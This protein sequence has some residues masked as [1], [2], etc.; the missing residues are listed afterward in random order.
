LLVDDNGTNECV[1]PPDEH[2]VH[3]VEIR[4][5]STV[6]SPVRRLSC[7]SVASSQSPE[8]ATHRRSS[9]SEALKKGGNTVLSVASRF[10]DMFKKTKN[11]VTTEM[12]TP[13]VL[14][15]RLIKIKINI[16]NCKFY[17]LQFNS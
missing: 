8:P 1:F 2:V 12:K 17:F 7:P 5:S 13:E 11:I 3:A 14:S 4:P 10:G 16:S 15:N 9:T 6:D